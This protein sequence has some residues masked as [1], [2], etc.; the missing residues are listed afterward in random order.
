MREKV[1][2]LKRGSI[3]CVKF[4]ENRNIEIQNHMQLNNQ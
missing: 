4:K 1:N 2:S 3:S